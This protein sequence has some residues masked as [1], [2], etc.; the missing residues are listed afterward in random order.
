MKSK[1]FKSLALGLMVLSLWSCKK[2]ETQTVSNITPA[3]T[4]T[5]SSTNLNLVQS[6]G[7]QAALT[8]S[9]PLSTVTGYVVPVTSTLQ[10]DLKG[11]NFSTPTEIV[12]TTG[13]YAPTVSQFNSMILALGGVV[14]TPAQVEVRLKSGAAVNDITYSNV[15]TLNATPYLASA[16]IYLPGAYQGW[17]PTTADSLVSLS[18]NGIYTGMIAFTADN[19]AFKIT[20]AKKWDGAYGDAGS[21]NISTSGGDLIS[22]DALVKQ[23]TV[24]L[25][26]KTIAFGT[27]NEW[28][29]IGDATPGGWTTD[30]DMKVTNDGKANFYTI[31]TNLTVGALKFRFQHDWATNLGGALGTLTTGGDN[32][33]ITAA[34]T[35]TITL[36]VAAKKATLVKN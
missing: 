12:L 27:P 14:G 36:D 20:P 5:A 8:L 18:S 23:V 35:Y 24:D 22:P 21:G 2:E 25:N 9:F 26:K 11:K 16:W 4:L 6:N 30:T 19:L 32:I 29:I 3:G 13:S 10:F 31:K 1:L 33:A 34:G 28:S 17:E 7:T 15:V